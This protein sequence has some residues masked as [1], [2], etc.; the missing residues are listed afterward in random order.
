MKLLKIHESFFFMSPPVTFV[1][2][3][4]GFTRHRSCQVPGGA[5]VDSRVL[6]LCV[7]DHQGTFVIIV[8]KGEMTAL[9]QKDVVLRRK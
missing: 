1:N 9:G 2:R 7:Q 5:G 6:R 3:E 8:D 4:L